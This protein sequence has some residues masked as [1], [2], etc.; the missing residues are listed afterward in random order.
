[1]E[2]GWAAL[3]SPA[4]CQGVT[5]IV[6]GFFYGYLSDN[7]GRVW[8]YALAI[9]NVAVFSLVS[10][11]SQNFATM[12]TLR[13][14]TSFGITGIVSTAS[15][16]LGRVL[17][18]QKSWKSPHTGISHSSSW[19]LCCRRFGMVA[20]TNVYGE[21]MEVPCYCYSIAVFFLDFVS[22]GVFY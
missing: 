19:K 17:A 18:S 15:S 16:N 12:I 10:A 20:D 7:Y 2:F 14:I 9:A 11:F 6:G 13:G 22:F 8:P 4:F 21:W 3:C 5:N 1:M